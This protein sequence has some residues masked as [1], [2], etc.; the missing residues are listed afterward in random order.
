MPPPPRATHKP[1]TST[2]AASRD[3][4]GAR[5]KLAASEKR[6]ATLRAEQSA[7]ASELEAERRRASHAAEGHAHELAQLKQAGFAPWALNQAGF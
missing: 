5:R 2:Q 4:D 6:V 3:V 1:H 7:A